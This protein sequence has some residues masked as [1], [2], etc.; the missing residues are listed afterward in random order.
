M[1]INDAISPCG[2]DRVTGDPYEGNV[3]IKKTLRRSL[4]MN[5]IN[6]LKRFQENL[7]SQSF[8]SPKG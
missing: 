5:D 8:S 7:T 1:E 4:Y 6:F 3:L 2:D